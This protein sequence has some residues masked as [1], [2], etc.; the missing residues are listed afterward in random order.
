MPWNRD[1]PR[2]PTPWVADHHPCHA[3]TCLYCHT[4]STCPRCDHDAS[5]FLL[6]S[7]SQRANTP[8]PEE[9]RKSPL[10]CPLQQSP[11]YSAGCKDKMPAET[12]VHSFTCTHGPQQ[13]TCAPTKIP[14]FDT[15]IKG[16][17][18]HC[19]VCT[20][21]ACNGWSLGIYSHSFEVKHGSGYAPRLEDSVSLVVPPKVGAPARLTRGFGSSSCP[22]NQL[23]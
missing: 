5:P 10:H 9:G 15:C 12:H 20:I 14:T 23:V 16:L 13:G 4:T 11:L 6:Q 21:G 17:P 22:H 1:L 3:N 7:S 8:T 19:M 18:T 2:S